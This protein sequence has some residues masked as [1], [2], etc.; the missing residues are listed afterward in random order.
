MRRILILAAIL[1]LASTTTTMATITD[2]IDP[3]GLNVQVGLINPDP[4]GYKGTVT[5]TA[6]LANGQIAQAPAGYRIDAGGAMT[7]TATF[8][9]TVVEVIEVGIIEN[10]DPIG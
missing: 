6:R 7:V 2:D 1:A 9:K 4:V 3:Q 5:V 8:K 10:P